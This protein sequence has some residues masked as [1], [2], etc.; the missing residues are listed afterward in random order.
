[1][2]RIN[3]CAA[4]KKRGEALSW[5]HIFATRNAEDIESQRT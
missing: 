4:S 5:S 3:K 1:M 2:L